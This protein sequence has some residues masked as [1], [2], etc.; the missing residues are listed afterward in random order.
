[1]AYEDGPRRTGAEGVEPRRGVNGQ[2]DIIRDPVTGEERLREA[3]W[4][5]AF[6]QHICSV[7]GMALWMII[8]YMTVGA[9]AGLLGG[10]IVGR[11][12]SALFLALGLFEGI[13]AIYPEALN[14][15]PYY[16]VLIGGL[17][18]IVAG[19]GFGMRHG[20]VTGNV[21]VSRAVL[22]PVIE[23]ALSLA[24]NDAPMDGPRGLNDRARVVA[25]RDVLD[26]L[27]ARVA[28]VEDYVDGFGVARLFR[29]Y[30]SVQ[31][32]DFLEDV[33]RVASAKLAEGSGQ[34][35]T[36]DNLARVRDAT[37]RWMQKY[38][39]QNSLLIIFTFVA[40]PIL[41]LCLLVWFPALTIFLL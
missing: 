23:R 3:D 30:V 4:R 34:A 12:V 28:A 13:K 40:M 35:L 38:A 39:R 8:L 15:V 25:A 1:M 32:V 6:Q 2:P 20:V 22:N 18:G 41:A 14:W 10:A 33:T 36:P 5:P 19:I 17:V 26:T 29:Q 31:C 11:G 24:R 21:S 7:I 9:L 37:L 16:Y 27:H